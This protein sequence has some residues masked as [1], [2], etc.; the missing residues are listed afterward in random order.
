MPVVINEFEII[1][2]QPPAPQGQEQGAEAL[3]GP[4]PAIRPE[5]IE[6]I[7]RRYRQRM[8]RVRAT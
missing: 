3:E 4:P 5:D 7:L 2:D 1:T 8:A 6:R